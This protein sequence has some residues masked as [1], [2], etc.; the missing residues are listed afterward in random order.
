M[1]GIETAL[2]QQR[3]EELCAGSIRALTGLADLHYRGRR[4]YQGEH[5][6]PVHAP[7]LQIDD[8]YED[9][10]S[11]R[12]I[13]DSI[14]LRIEY[15]NP[16][17]HTKLCP[18][19]PVERMLFE[20]L[21]QLRVESLV[22]ETLPGVGHNLFHR[23][24][25]WSMAF[26]HSGLTE[27]E[28]GILLYTVAQMAWARINAVAVLE[29]TED[30]LESTRA[31]LAPLLGKHFEAI[32]RERKNQAAFASHALAIARI[33]AEGVCETL[34]RTDDSK[35]GNRERHAI[36]S[37]LVDFDEQSGE[38]FGIAGCGH[39]KTLDESPDGYRVFTRRYDRETTA[40]RLVRTG[41]LEEMR[42]QL[43]L[44]VRQQAIN[45]P[46]LARLFRAM[47]SRPQQDGWSFG[48]EEGYVDGG[49]LSQLVCSPTER[50]LFRR[51]R[52]QPR[53]NSVFSILIDCSGSMKQHIDGLSVLVDVMARALELAEVKTEI[54][55][56]TTNAWSG[57][58]AQRD[59]LRSG[60]PQI[61]GRLN[62]SCHLIFKS[63]DTP[64]RRA[65]RDIASLMKKDLFREGIDGEAV[66]WACGR[67]ALRNEPRRILMVISD[68]SPMDTATAL[69]N[70]PYYLDNH[71]QRVVQ[72]WSASGMVEIIGLGVG[73]DL[74]PYYDRCVAA[75]LSSGLSNSLFF[76]MMELLRGHHRR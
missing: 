42:R 8:A 26:Y 38:G 18:D 75:D 3:V 2:Q 50:R 25:R 1:S 76:D 51:D 27:T 33:V 24:E 29:Q 28:S 4:L 5:R 16:D 12:G 49:R 69:A 62:E 30:L 13:G 48:E 36:F 39:S 19:A 11:Y 46:G 66:D 23:F 63:A 70:D 72:S 47:L 68:G 22:P 64:W 15:S 34:V 6:I 21:E 44:R 37:L 54:L 52:L 60:R 43:D 74:S 56:F 55:G 53:A 9:I 67:L 10:I 59:W 61:P 14:A 35:S 71:L 40:G 58:R 57:G 7:H 17:L 41:L 65:R 20:L 45:I 32:R 73:L 31:S